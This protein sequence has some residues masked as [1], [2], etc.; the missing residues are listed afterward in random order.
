M[1]TRVAITDEVTGVSRFRSVNRMVYIAVTLSFGCGTPSVPQPSF[2]ERA[3]EEYDSKESPTFYFPQAPHSLSGIADETPREECSKFLRSIQ[4]PSLSCGHMVTEAYRLLF[5]PSYGPAVVILA[6]STETGWRLEVHEFRHPRTSRPRTVERHVERTLTQ[7]EVRT[8]LDG[9]RAADF[10]T[11][12]AWKNSLSEDGATWV[13]EGR[14]NTG[15][16]VVG[17]RSP[18]LSP[19]RRQ[20]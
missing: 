2:A 5:L 4:A 16:R 13:L 19:S 1:G 3:H 14:L 11:T 17:R 6:R 15:S 9:L 12:P 18:A 20:G 10:W 7:D 8:L